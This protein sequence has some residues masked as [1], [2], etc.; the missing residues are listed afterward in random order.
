MSPV[1]L[2]KRKPSPSLTF[3]AR[4]MPS[5]IECSTPSVSTS[6][7]SARSPC[8]R[9]ATFRCST[10]REYCGAAVALMS[11]GAVFERS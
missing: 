2:M 6:L 11:N 3:R 4:P 8:R 9:S 5:F 10:T 7:D 1:W